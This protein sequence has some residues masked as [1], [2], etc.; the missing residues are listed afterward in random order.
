MLPMS[1]KGLSGGGSEGVGKGVVVGVE[2][3]AGAAPPNWAAISGGRGT[4]AASVSAAQRH[5]TKRLMS[6]M[7]FLIPANLFVE[8]R[9]Y[10]RGKGPRPSAADRGLAA[11]QVE[12]RS[13]AMI[14]D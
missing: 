9:H 4:Q 6:Y 2:V 13:G 3:A 11:A 10:T 8:C 12:E 5:S 1:V 14:S 7:G